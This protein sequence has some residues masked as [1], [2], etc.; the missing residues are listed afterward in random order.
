MAEGMAEKEK[1][2]KNKTWFG[3]LFGVI[4]HFFFDFHSQQ[5]YMIP[6]FS[7]FSHLKQTLSRSV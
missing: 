2:K 6:F 3:S 7:F 5:L 1:R 4:S